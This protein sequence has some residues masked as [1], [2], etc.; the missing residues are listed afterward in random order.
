MLRRRHQPFDIDSAA[1]DAWM[2]CM[3]QAL[4]ETCPDE[5]L[6]A[7]LDAA[8]YKVAEVIR[9]RESGGAARAHPGRPHGLQPD[10]PALPH[11]PSPTRSV[12]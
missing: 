3:R 8:F 5:A 1:R 12:P 7:E 4:A 9:N 10:L 2:A 6:R 11:T